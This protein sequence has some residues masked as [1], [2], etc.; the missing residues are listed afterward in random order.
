MATIERTTL[1]LASQ[2]RALRCNA[3]R[4]MAV[5]AIDNEINVWWRAGDD[6]AAQGCTVVL[7]PDGGVIPDGGHYLGPVVLFAGATVFHVFVTDVEE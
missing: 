6:I 5:A 1:Q 4:V 2:R 7:V 3:T